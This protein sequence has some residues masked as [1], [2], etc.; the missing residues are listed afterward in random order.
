MK[1][2]LSYIRGKHMTKTDQQYLTRLWEDQLTQ[3][4]LVSLAIDC[5]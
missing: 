1:H 3:D 4:Y 2:A 5:Q